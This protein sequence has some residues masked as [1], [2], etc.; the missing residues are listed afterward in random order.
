[1]ITPETREII[2]GDADEEKIRST[3]TLLKR[4]VCYV[5]KKKYSVPARRRR[6]C[7]SRT[8]RRWPWFLFL[9]MKCVACVCPREKTV[10]EFNSRE[11]D[12]AE[13]LGCRV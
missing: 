5:L 8:R 11:K 2:G 4:L 12:A 1:M 6:T 3:E 13:N 10:R 7:C 9:L